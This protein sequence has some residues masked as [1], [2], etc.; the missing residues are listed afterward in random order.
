MFLPD[1]KVG[2]SS[3]SQVGSGDPAAAKFDSLTTIPAEEKSRVMP[4]MVRIAREL[5]MSLTISDSIRE[6]VG[7]G[8]AQVEI[9]ILENGQWQLVKVSGDPYLR[10]HVYERL[11]T[12][13]DDPLLQDAS[14]EAGTKR[15]RVKVRLERKLADLGDL[16]SNAKD[17][18]ID[19]YQITLPFEG[20]TR[21]E[22]EVALLPNKRIKAGPATFDINPVGAQMSVDIGP[23]NFTAIAT[24]YGFGYGF[25]PSHKDDKRREDFYRQREIQA[26]KDSP[27]FLGK[28][29]SDR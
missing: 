19:G 7:Y 14:R 27:A 9:R 1:A 25:A 17:Y 28:P 13:K 29:G 21:K 5:S 4:S 8:D 20:F 23:V 11:R 12:L 10:A 18:D 26:L 2:T 16:K 3:W 22:D 24:P 6:L 15:I